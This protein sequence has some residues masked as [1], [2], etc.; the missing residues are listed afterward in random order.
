VFIVSDIIDGISSLL[1]SSLSCISMYLLRALNILM[2]D[3]ILMIIFN[4]LSS[5]FFLSSLESFESL[6]LF[7]EWSL[8]KFGGT[9]DFGIFKDYCDPYTEFYPV[10]TLLSYDVAFL[11]FILIICFELRTKDTFLWFLLLGLRIK[12]NFFSSGVDF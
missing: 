6:E 11:V 9:P 3:W 4:I 8:C 5:F 2:Q 1:S 10:S 7:L 12:F